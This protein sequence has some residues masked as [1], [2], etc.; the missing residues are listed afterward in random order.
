MARRITLV[1]CR[2]SGKSSV[3]V[4]LAVR[5]GALA[6]D[7]DAEVEA[8]S[9]RS[10][11]HIFAE[12]GETAFRTYEHE[13]LA[14]VLEAYPEAIIATGGGVVERA[15]NRALL[16]E[17]GRPVVY[18]QAAAAVLAARLSADDGGRPSLTGQAVAEEVATLLARREP[19]YRAV[20]DHVVDVD[21]PLDEVV[22]A[23]L[24]ALG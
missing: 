5:T 6:L 15:D 21:R 3:A 1:G 12:S 7:L 11:A 8:R 18:L 16:R 22:S 2:G 19:W 14:A 9:G 13:V 20:A 24:A 17:R 10:I 23:V 4:A